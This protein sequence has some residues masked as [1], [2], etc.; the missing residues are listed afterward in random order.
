MIIMA[1]GSGARL[2]PLSRSNFP[3]QFLKLPGGTKSIL[4]LTIERCK[5]MGSLSD[6]YIVTSESYLSLINQQLSEIGEKLPKEQ[7]LLEPQ[8]KNTLPAILYAVQ[9]IREKGDDICAVFASDHVIDEPQILADTVL[10]A[11]N[12]AAK[13]FVCFGITPTHPETG[14]GYIKPGKPINGGNEVSAFKEKPDHETAKAY[15]KSGYLW[16][17]GIFM[18][19]SAMFYDAVKQYNPEVFEAFQESTAKE[20][21]SK[22]PS[23]SV[24]YGL[25]E[26]MYTV[27]CVPLNM[28]WKDIGN[29]AAL[30]EKYALEKDEGGNICYNDEVLIDSYGNFCLTQ[31]KKAVALIG[32]NDLIVIEQDDALLIC[33]KDQTQKVRDVVDELKRR[34]D[35]RE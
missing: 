21:F 20:K 18:F 25:I 32:V 16:N 31:S 22:A 17:S 5:L 26:K 11:A 28:K 19:D 29:F 7:I 14:F 33:H 8:A 2:W 30:S 3:K 15:V 10:S 6:L 23:I 12:L 27:F 34:G 1:G 4:Q 24:D 35:T 13:G 9:T